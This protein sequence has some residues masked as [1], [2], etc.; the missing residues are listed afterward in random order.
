MADGSGAGGTLLLI[1]SGSYMVGRG[2]GSSCSTWPTCLGSLL[3]AGEVYMVHMSHRYV[4]ALAGLLVLA[5][6]ITHY[7]LGRFDPS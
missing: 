6:L 5:Q 4:A 2:F 1:L 3:P 7:L